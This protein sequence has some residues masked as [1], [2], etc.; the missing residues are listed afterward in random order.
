MDYRIPGLDGA[1]TARELRGRGYDRPILAV[2]ASV[3]SEEREE[4]L[5]SGMNDFLTK[6]LELALLDVALRAQLRDR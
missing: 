3:T 5:G 4:C 6:P 1:A 2:T